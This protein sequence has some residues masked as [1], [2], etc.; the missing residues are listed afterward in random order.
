MSVIVPCNTR[1][2]RE[3]TNKGHQIGS[4]LQFCF[5]SGVRAR[6]GRVGRHCVGGFNQDVSS[7]SCVYADHVC[8]TRLS[9]GFFCIR[10]VYFLLN[11]C[12]RYE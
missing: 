12:H 6:A 1:M 11:E 7:V 4:F 3:K 9:M 10:K 2:L 5:L 8:Y